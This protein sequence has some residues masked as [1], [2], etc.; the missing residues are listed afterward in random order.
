[1]PANVLYNFVKKEYE[2]GTIL[3]ADIHSR[4]IS[5]LERAVQQGAVPEKY[6]LIDLPPVDL[7]ITYDYRYKLLE[8]HISIYEQVD[9]KNVYLS[10]YHYTAYFNNNKGQEYQLHVYVDEKDQPVLIEFAIRNPEGSCTKIK[11]KKD[12]QVMFSELAID[13]MRLT[14]GNL[15]EKH[16]EFSQSL[17]ADYEIL[18]NN[19]R[20]LKSNHDEKYEPLLSLLL[21]KVQ[22]LT[23]YHANPIYKRQAK[24]LQQIMQNYL[25]NPVSKKTVY[26][27]QENKKEDSQEKDVEE[28]DS[29]QEVSE[30]V[31]IA[32]KPIKKVY[33]ENLSDY[34]PKLR[35]L[36]KDLDE[37]SASFE[38]NEDIFPCFLKYLQYCDML[39]LL[40]QENHI[41]ADQETLKE[42]R[43]HY[44]RAHLEARCLIRS[45]LIAGKYDLIEKLNDDLG[46]SAE[47]WFTAALL[48]GDS[49]ALEFVLTHASVAINSLFIY[50]NYNPVMYCF[51]H[52]SESQ[53]KVKCLA[54]LLDYGASIFV[55]LEDGFSVAN[56]ILRDANHPLLDA[57]RCQL[58]PQVE[59]C[60]V[61]IK[62][63][64][65]KINK[66]DDEV[67]RKKLILL[68]NN[69]NIHLSKIKSVSNKEAF[70]YMTY[71]VYSPVYE[72]KQIIDTIDVFLMEPDTQQVINKYKECHK[73]YLKNLT[74]LQR[75]KE[76]A[77]GHD[78]LT[79]LTGML[80]RIHVDLSDALKDKFKAMLQIHICIIKNKM[81]IND[82]KKELK[83]ANWHRKEY[84]KKEIQKLEEENLGLDEENVNELAAFVLEGDPFKNQGVSFC[85]AN[86]FPSENETAQVKQ[87][88]EEKSPLQAFSLLGNAIKVPIDPHI[89]LIC[90]PRRPKSPT[91]N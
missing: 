75:S 85:E 52:H 1:M 86:D 83:G 45:D 64:D 88:N 9:P 41:Y 53:S 27:V 30:K 26:S 13:R 63:I 66:V 79:F 10:R 6:S 14:M 7:T 50:N 35:A 2:E 33:K 46:D 38:K 68:K 15:Q 58:L 47:M 32:K 61:V 72:N 82:F 87:K 31:D 20:Q 23:L 5:L 40:T 51:L 73:A 57:L 21:E 42:I 17:V 76:V 59:F 67:I 37:A 60:K 24:L 80:R 11:I 29:K 34:L 28:K 16:R 43:N 77:D 74:S 70:K 22:A 12:L 78:T 48:A 84:L 91:S 90:V 71:N 54:A 81:A 49:K 18:E 8:D 19:L 25:S 69:F 55:K 3:P 89:D 36:G 56:H 65:E 4:K 62:E 44:T 39:E